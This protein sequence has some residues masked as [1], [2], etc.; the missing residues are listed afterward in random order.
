MNTQALEGCTEENYFSD[1]HS[2]LDM[3]ELQASTALCTCMIA[4][5]FAGCFALGDLSFIRGP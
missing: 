5:V 2:V 1:T 4:C 3:S